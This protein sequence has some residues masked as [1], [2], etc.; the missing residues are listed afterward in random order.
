MDGDPSDELWLR[1]SEVHI[2][3]RNLWTSQKVVLRIG[4]SEVEGQ[5][6][7]IHLDQDLLGKGGQPTA[8]DSPVKGIE[9]L[10]L[11]YVDR[12]HFD[13]ARGGI[14][15]PKTNDGTKLPA[16]AD[17]KCGGSF[18][19][20]F[21]SGW[22]EL[23]G[24]SSSGVEVIHQ[25]QDQVEDRFQCDQ[26][27]LHF[28]K[29]LATPTPTSTADQKAK[30]AGWNIDRMEANG[31][32]NSEESS[33]NWW[34]RLNVPGLQ[35]RAQGRRLAIDM[36]LGRLT[37]S[38]QLPGSTGAESSRAFFER[39][40][41]RVWSPEVIIESEQWAKSNAPV[42]GDS[43]DS[44][45]LG[46]LWA[47]GPG[48]AQMA[49]QEGDSWKLSWAKR[50]T[51]VPDGEEDLLT[52]DGSANISSQLQ[53]RFFAERFDVWLKQVSLAQW[54]SFKSE[55]P[56]SKL[57][58]VLADR[59][60]ANGQV[61]IDSQQLRAQVD[62]MR[63][64]FAYPQITRIQEKK[65]PTGLQLFGADGTMPNKIVQPMQTGPTLPSAGPGQLASATS[66]A[67]ANPKPKKFA[68]PLNVTGPTLRAR[69]V[70]E[71]VMRI[72]DLELEGGVTMTIDQLSEQYALPLTIH[73]STLTTNTSEDGN[74]DV[75]I[76]GN[77]AQIKI[78]D[79]VLEGP[80]VR[81]NQKDQLVWMDHPGFLV[82]PIEVLQKKND[83]KKGP[84]LAPSPTSNM[85]WLVP[86]KIEW[87]GSMV[88][89]GKVARIQ[90]DVSLS[91]DVQTGPDSRWLLQ[92][93]ADS[94]DVHL[95]QAIPMRS[96][97][98]MNS[99]IARIDLKEKVDL[100]AMETNARGEQLSL[101]RLS[102]P[103]LSIDMKTQTLVGGGWVGS[104]HVD[105]DQQPTTSSRPLRRLAQGKVVNNFS[106][107][108]S[109]SMVDWMATW[110]TDRSRF[111]TMLKYSSV[112]SRTGNKHW[113]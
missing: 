24:G 43:R 45:H 38:N 57:S 4:Q 100:R 30:F 82:I 60:H 78:G 74:A 28:A 89:D 76:L 97:G 26:L 112:R 103:W 90:G 22:A 56:N 23:A 50:L 85:N 37:L 55:N 101:E 98:S 19:F 46:T 42:P 67:P 54:E 59:F 13:L 99:E 40:N 29:G 3:R 47:A 102:V 51:L 18:S 66:G 75:Q 11:R 21:H 25:V 49:T 68:Y 111:R 105:L 5:D 44:N 14:W 94:M 10:E 27:R 65:E 113:T 1:T 96:G 12:V 52:I 33:D 41:L 91:G 39:E 80:E 61:I 71:D 92:G 70:V 84:L 93:N 35:T 88:F 15:S 79:G 107:S 16:F 95:T 108:I 69:L 72:D 8:V 110:P 77:P 87:K 17:V 83:P 81:F 31:R 53:G 106:V 32:L 58:R 86:P 63:V 20:D 36:S 109:A 6:L 64:W 48:T 73:G 7:S 104:D 9:K 2:D 34:V 62:D